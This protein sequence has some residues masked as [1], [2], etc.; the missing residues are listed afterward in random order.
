MDDQVNGNLLKSNSNVSKEV[1]LSDEED[2]EDVRR[3]YSC[4]YPRI[5][6]D[7]PG[8]KEKLDLPMDIVNFATKEGRKRY[9]RICLEIEDAAVEK[10]KDDF[11][12][13]TN[14]YIEQL[15]RERASLEQHHNKKI[16]E[17]REEKRLLEE[18]VAIINE[19][20]LEARKRGEEHWTKYKAYV[21][22]DPCKE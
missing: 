17:L 13:T 8:C 2:K 22:R 15:K 19:K 7:R 5:A 11:L 16:N 20:I 14:L 12:T 1:T 18:G 10:G 9:K 21:L 4:G 6:L 3:N